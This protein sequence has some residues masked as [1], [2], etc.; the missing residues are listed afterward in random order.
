LTDANKAPAVFDAPPEA[1]PQSFAITEMITCE[2]CLRNNPPT[3]T[4]C[5][6]CGAQLSVGEY[7]REQKTTPEPVSEPD[8]IGPGFHVVLV[9]GQAKAPAEVSLKEIAALL[10]MQTNEIESVVGLNRPIPL[11]RSATFEEGTRMAD[12]LRELGVEVS[13]L[14][15]DGLELDVPTRKIRSLELSEEC[16]KAHLTIGGPVSIDWSELSLMVAGRLL[17]SRRESEERQGRRGSKPVDSRELFSDEPLV[18]LYRKSDAVGFRISVNSFDFSCLGDRKAMTAFE[19]LATVINL[20]KTR[21]PG[22]EFDDSYRSLRTVLNN[23]WPLEP[24]TRKGE[25][26]RSGVGKVDV[27]T[28]TILDNENQFNTYSRL[29]QQIESSELEGE[30]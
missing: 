13:V 28:I 14:P 4:N 8:F 10:R 30:R 12:R 19:N 23:V 20:V 22:I 16:L 9:P 15:E 2:E 3:R 26:R 6:Y 18:D 21:A 27:S 7:A 1:K 29:R 25:W 17:V 24:Q 5:L 11:L